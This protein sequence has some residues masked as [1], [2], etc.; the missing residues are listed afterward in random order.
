MDSPE[1][2]NKRVAEALGWGVSQSV[3]GS[4]RWFCGQIPKT[5]AKPTRES[6][7]RNLPDFCR[8]A[9]AADLV[10]QEIERRMWEW[11]TET[12]LVAGVRSW[13]ACATA[14]PSDAGDSTR[15][16][17]S[18]SSPHMALCLAF[19]ATHDEQPTE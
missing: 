15:W 12:R 14:T 4:W 13:W 5:D 3:T 7:E 17:Q 18:L 1:E 11:D 19:L 16:K 9:S 8:D 10:R 6:A 2:I